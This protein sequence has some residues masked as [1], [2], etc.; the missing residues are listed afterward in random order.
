MQL[1]SEDVT[2]VRPLELE[3]DMLVDP[4]PGPA[5]VETAGPEPVVVDPDTLPPPAVI[6]ELMLPADEAE[7]PGALSPGFRCT[8]L[9][10]LLLGPEFDD[11]L[12][13]SEEAEL[14]ELELSACAAAT[15]AR[16]TTVAQNAADFMV[17]NP[18]FWGD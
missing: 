3:V 12:L 4:L 5:W 15:A 1:P 7:P 11:A 9:Q 14:D 10:L 13:P 2:T 18:L 8:V 17:K 6:W 16:A